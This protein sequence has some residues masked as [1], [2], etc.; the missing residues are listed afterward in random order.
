MSLPSEV[1]LSQENSSAEISAYYSYQQL[2]VIIKYSC[3]PSYHGIIG[4]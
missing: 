2:S 1:V 4:V 3:T